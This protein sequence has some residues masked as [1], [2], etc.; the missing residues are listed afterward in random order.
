MIRWYADFGGMPGV[1][2]CAGG[3]RAEPR[4]SD[5]FLFAVGFVSSCKGSNFYFYFYL[6]FAPGSLTC[7]VGSG[8]VPF[9]ALGS[10]GV[11]F[12]ALGVCSW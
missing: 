7:V 8:G 10:G 11:P 12:N 5:A 6:P 3:M 4:D 2:A 9:N 1:D